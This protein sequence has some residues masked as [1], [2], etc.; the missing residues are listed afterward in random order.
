M[1]IRKSTLLTETLF[2]EAAAQAQLYSSIPLPQGKTAER[3]LSMN[4]TVTVKDAACGVD[5]VAVAGVIALHLVVETAERKPFAFDASAEFSHGVAMAGVT[6]EMSARVLAEL[7]AC[8][9][10]A[11]E[12]GLRMEATVSLQT[13]VLAPQALACITG[14][15]DAKGLQTLTQSV[16]L[17]KRILLGAH[18]CRVR[19]VFD[20][21]NGLAVLCAEGTPLVRATRYLDDAMTVEGAINLYVLFSD[22]EGGIRRE[23]YGMSFSDS[24]PCERNAS[25]CCSVT[26]SKLYADA[27]EDGTFSIE[28]VLS[29]GLYGVVQTEASLLADAYDAAGSFACQKETATCLDYCG[30]Q[31]ESVS[32]AESI[33]VP[34]HLP[35]CYMPL[36][37]CVRP[38]LTGRVQDDKETLFEGI[39]DATVVYRADDG[40]KQSFRAELP[41]SLAL[42]APN[43]LLLPK[44]SV[45]DVSISG[46]GRV[47]RLTA[48]L[49]METE[50]YDARALTYTADLTQGTPC[51]TQAGILVYFADA[52]ETF[53]SVGKRFGVPVAQVQRCNP[54][55][56]E[57]LQEGAPI[58][59]FRKN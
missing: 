2:G 25:V 59:L 7:L 38:V 24:I 41:W 19:E 21:P 37:A 9:C 57:P 47:V 56:T 42:T 26:L 23:P 11:E 31:T 44:V 34:N 43:G 33:P 40:M 6:A 55:R 28:A 51:E 35:E 18:A 14:L 15:E 54:E 22:A 45:T 30:A 10:R 1:D 8:T 58:L 27:L 4:A 48:E 39:L 16:T 32:V 52:G 3:L 20:T 13:A 49:S 50:C 12:G 53:F 17:N 36:Y 46:G 5:T 29:I